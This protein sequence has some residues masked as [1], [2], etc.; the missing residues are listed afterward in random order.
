[1]LCGKQRSRVIFDLL[2]YP[3]EGDEE[4]GAVH[5]QADAHETYEHELV[6]T[7]LVADAAFRSIDAVGHGLAWK[8]AVPRYARGRGAGYRGGEETVKGECESGGPGADKHDLEERVREF[9]GRVP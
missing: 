2:E 7:E 5:H 6:V 9:P 3:E 8:I 1:M 4:I